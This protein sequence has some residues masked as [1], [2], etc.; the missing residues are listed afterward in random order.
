MNSIVTVPI[1]QILQALQISKQYSHSVTKILST[2]EVGN[3]YIK[4]K[5]AFF[6]EKKKSQ[7]Y[8]KIYK[9]VYIYINKPD[10]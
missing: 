6:P 3:S 7:T 2:L 10:T 9:Y 8:K 4:Y 5:S 1:S